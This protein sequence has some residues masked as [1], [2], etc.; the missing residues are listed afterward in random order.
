[1]IFGSV[2]HCDTV[3][4][5]FITTMKEFYENGAKSSP[6]GHEIIELIN[7]SLVISCPHQCLLNHPLRSVSRKYVGAE[8]LWYLSGSL[9]VAEISKYASMWSKVCDADGNVNSNYGDLIFNDHV[10]MLEGK[11]SQFDWCASLLA[12]DKDSR[13][14]VINLNLLEHKFSETKDFPCTLSLQF[15]IR[16][17]QLHMITNM[18]SNDFVFGFLN[19][20]PF[21][22]FVHQ[23]MFDTARR[24]HDNLMIGRYIHNAASMHIYERH[25][26][27]MN[28]VA[29]SSRA[30]GTAER[31]D[32]ISLTDVREYRKSGTKQG[33]IKQLHDWKHGENT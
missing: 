7:Y 13:Q 21:F 17:N 26:D 9:N 28:E 1:M 11:S 5:A 3:R 22:S 10:R 6:R 20:F 19:D 27:L 14:A 23:L 18:R 30:K 16:D 4:E 12:K 25:Y 33:V 2:H 15:L 32:P 8:I 31:F 24:S 29:M